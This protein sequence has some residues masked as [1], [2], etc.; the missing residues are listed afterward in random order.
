[1]PHEFHCTRRFEGWRDCSP[2]G[3]FVDLRL[4]NDIHLT[5]GT[6]RCACTTDTPS[7][8][9]RTLVQTIRPSDVLLMRAQPKETLYTIY[10][11][12]DVSK[13]G[14]TITL[15]RWERLRN[16]EGGG[17]R[18]GR[19]NE[20]VYTE[21]KI[22]M[23]EGWGEAGGGVDRAV[24]AI[25]RAIEFVDPKETVLPVHLRHNGA[26]DRYFFR[27]TIDPTTNK[28]LPVTETQAR[29]FASQ[30]PPFMPSP[31]KLNALDL[32]CGGG[33]LGRGVMD[34]GLVECRWAVDNDS[35]ALGTY[36]TNTSKNRIE[37][38]KESINAVLKGV[39]NRQLEERLRA[40]DNVELLLVGC[41]CQAFC[42]SNRRK[43]RKK[44]ILQGSLVAGA[45]SFLELYRHQSPDLLF[46]NVPEICTA[47]LDVK[48]RTLFSHL[49]A[50]ILALGYQVR[51]EIL[52]AANFGVAQAICPCSV[53]PPHTASGKTLPEMPLI[54]HHRN[55]SAKRNKEASQAT[56][57]RVWKSRIGE[58]RDYEVATFPLLT[59][60]EII[61][62]LPDIG[63]GSS[64]D[65][66]SCRL[67]HFVA[68]QYG[69]QSI[70]DRIPVE[71][72][73]CSLKHLKDEV[74]KS[75]SRGFRVQQYH[76]QKPNLVYFSLNKSYIPESFARVARTGPFPTI[77]GHIGPRAFQSRALHY[78]QNRVLTVREC[79]RAQ[80]FLDEEY[81]F[82]RS[83]LSQRIVV[84]NAVPRPLAFA[85]GLELRKARTN[86]VTSPSRTD[87]D[88]DGSTTPANPADES[89]KF[90][91]LDD[92]GA[93][94][95]CVLTIDKDKKVEN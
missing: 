82:G 33:S 11:V 74:Y 40:S 28:V 46:E 2:T 12:E 61:G 52:T 4:P 53:T 21:T 95:Q 23:L 68:K 6:P 73:R 30:Y 54:S 24:R 35:D 88:L 71:P 26:G 18:T 65:A 94:T 64:V 80:G 57:G 44:Y 20:L 62:D 67:Q 51:W 77:T 29:N 15:R 36:I 69:S 84:G 42:R 16:V 93:R 17:W 27:K 19:Q 45:L 87:P 37:F 31:T 83:E 91:K 32:C 13:L 92:R 75:M 60:E 50:Y 8:Q 55:G 89:V 59:A 81:I 9:F 76:T 85:L 3:A 34:A 63:N 43:N 22:V 41:P 14:G 39:A 58:L 79:A 47:Q 56:D 78:A 66:A 49:V 7:N 5:D 48:G 72:E 10:T 25:G 70:I 1:G 38:I 86:D 90:A